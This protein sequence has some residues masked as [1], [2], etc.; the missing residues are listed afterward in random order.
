MSLAKATLLA[1]VG[2]A[3]VGF[4]YSFVY[5]GL[6]VEAISGIAPKNRGTVMGEYTAFLD[7]AMAVGGPLWLG[8]V[9][10]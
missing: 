7:V 4:K 9:V 8:P 3:L 10:M 5:L 6:G 2:A 1:S